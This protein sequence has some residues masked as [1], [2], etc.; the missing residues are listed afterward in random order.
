MGYFDYHKTAKNLIR[1]GKLIESRVLDE[2][3][4]ISPAL[5]LVFDDARHP[6]MPIRKEKWNEY[7][8]L[9]NTKPKNYSDV[10]LL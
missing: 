8:P 9:L 10:K 1:Q 6:V 3:N 2:Y 7:M 5:L 4:G